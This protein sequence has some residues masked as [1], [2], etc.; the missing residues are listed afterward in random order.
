MGECAIF[1]SLV[2][3][4]KPYNGCEQDNWRFHKEVSL[5]LHPAFIEIKHDCV[6]RFVSIGN[7]RHQFRSQRI[8]TVAFSRIIEV[9][10]IKFRRYLVT[11]PILNQMVIGDNGQIIKLEVIYV[12]C[13]GFLDSLLNELI[14]NRIW[15][16]APRCSEYHS[17][18]KNI[19]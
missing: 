14:D 7:I 15:F 9:Y 13:I 19:Y 8:T 5:L 2:Q 12:K 6:T 16:S 1:P 3:L 11:V 18:T 10:Y 17:R 4:Q